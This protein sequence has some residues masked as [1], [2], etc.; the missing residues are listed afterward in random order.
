MVVRVVHQEQ[1]PRAGI[2]NKASLRLKI[3]VGTW[4]WNAST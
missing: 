1:D 2:E 4:W 3:E